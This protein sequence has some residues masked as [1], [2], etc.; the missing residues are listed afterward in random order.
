MHTKNFAKFVPMTLLAAGCLQSA[1]AIDQREEPIIGGATTTADPG[2]VMLR[3][4]TGGNGY[5]LCTAEVVS[6]HVIMTAAHCVT[7]GGTFDIF[8]GN[9]M[10]GAEGNDATKWLA[11]SEAHYNPSFNEQQLDNGQ[12]V[13]VAILTNATSI[14]PLPMN[15]TAL[16]NT[17]V[18]QPVRI[19]GFGINSSSDT[20]GNS[21]GTKR[22]ATTPL[23]SYDSLF[24]QFGNAS[25]DTCE[26]DSGGPAF[27]TIGGTEVITGI[28]SFGVTGCKGGAT[29]TRVD[30]VS[31]KF[32]DPYIAKFDPQG[33]SP[34]DMAGPAPKPDMATGG[35]GGGGGV[36][37]PDMG[38]GGGGGGGGG[39]GV[40]GGGG[41]NNPLGSDC[42]T[43]ADCASGLCLSVSGA[44][45][46]T[47]TC[48]PSDSNSCPLGFEC[49]T[50]FGS[51]RCVHTGNVNVPTNGE[52]A[53][54]GCSTA[55]G[56]PGGSGAMAL[57]LASLLGA[58]SLRRRGRSMMWLAALALIVSGCDAS[59]GGRG[60]GTGGVGGGG[61]GSDGGGGGGG[62]GGGDDS[63]VPQGCTGSDPNG[64]EDH[65]GYT[66][67]TGDC[68]DCDPL[69][70]PAAVDVAGNMVDDDCDGKIDNP[71]AACDTMNAGKNDATSL[72]Q[73]MEQCDPRFFLSASLVG[74]SDAKARAVASKF[75]ILTP[76]AGANMTLLSTGLAVD[77]TGAGFV[78]VQD[79][80]N[81]GNS[82]TFA[83]PEPNLMGVAGCSQSQPAMVND[84]TELVLKLKAPSN[85]NSF[86]F[87]FQFFSAEY[88][89]FV[90]TEFNDEFL[91]EMESPGEFTT[92]TNITFDSKMNPITINNGLFTVCTNSTTQY[93]MN[94]KSPVTDIAGTG[95][96]DTSS[97]LLGGKDPIGGSTGW[98]TTTAPVTPNEE[99]T[100][101]F[102]IFDEGDHI[103]DSAVL[104]DNFQWSVVAA[105]A[106]MTIN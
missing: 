105:M 81:L 102:I 28:T 101:H 83:N 21:A 17:Q 37:S 50:A 31:V 18:G 44:S 5:S 94:C 76:K 71:L 82:N 55:P 104:I 58:L 95:Y 3:E 48:T 36:P 26:G 2:V 67:A 45:V 47:Q 77:K 65:D 40:G 93:T 69:V 68:N 23:T 100:L 61:S 98:L 97:G 14:K 66:P 39:G 54:T 7:G 15:R 38:T 22:V 12:D 73:A 62:G 86:S 78:A 85:A 64:D 106:P 103:Y 41:G 57:L 59:N 56:Q 30:T 25:Q 72:S 43:A 11:V 6:P 32:V 79:G 53:G 1:S 52:Q 84:Y 46:C 96:E 33:S 99:V 13:A 29:D 42:T 87:Q 80:T 74:P 92:A 19:V 75:G 63:G 20:Q 27:M 70:N 90:C 91:V 88:P 10:N 35:G 16:T 9:D 89:E 24:V 8:I 51:S 34:P 49:E 60:H 4:T